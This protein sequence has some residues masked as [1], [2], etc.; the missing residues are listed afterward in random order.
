MQD[1][2]IA[3]TIILEECCHTEAEC[4]DAGRDYD[5]AES[6]DREEEE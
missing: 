4:S 2:R 5:L 3:H 1:I 6:S